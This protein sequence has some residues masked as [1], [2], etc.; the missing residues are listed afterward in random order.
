MAPDPVPPPDTRA[1]LQDAQRL[2]LDDRLGEAEILYRRLL[3]QQPGHAQGLGMLAMLLADQPGRE[4]EAETALH[5]HLAL[6]PADGA[7]LHRLGRLKAGQGDDAAA[8]ALFRRAAVQ[9]PKLAPVFNDLG[10]SLN[11][12][13]ERQ[14]ALAALDHA[15]ALDPV[16]GMAHVNRG[17]VLSDLKQFDQATRAQL[18]ALLHLP[19]TRPDWSAATLYSLLRVVRKTGDRA[20]AETA[21]GIVLATGPTDGGTIDELA[22]LLEYLGR[23]DE[24]RSLRNDVARRTGIRRKAPPSDAEATVLLLGGVGAGHL[25]TRYLVDAQVFATLSVELLSPDQPDAPLGGVDVDRLKDADVVFNTLGEADRDGGQFDAVAA[26]C[27]RLGRPVL[28]PPDAIRRTGRDQATA[29]FGD[30]PDLVTPA[31][32][33]ATPDQ[34]AVLPID[35]PLLVRPAG[36]HGGENLTLLRDTADRDRYLQ[37]P[38]PAAARL[39]LTRFHDFRSPDGHW[40][41]YRLIFVDRRIHPYHLAIGDDW[42]VHYWRTEMSLAPWKK[43]EEA[44]F[45]ADWRGVF[46]APA[47]RAAEE[48]ARR[49]D[50]DYGGMDC[51]LLDDGRLLLF[52]ANACMRV[53]L[54]EPVEAFPY[55]HRHVPAIRDAFSAMV[56][57]R[58][59]AKADFAQS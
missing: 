8:A 47:T 33:A 46:G 10:V 36:D 22:L 13:G 4:A 51:A 54:D 56:R 29:L 11:R 9:L 19:R 50:L 2:H 34:L 30:I 6:R 18:T 14:E 35:A 26:L 53:H 24:A 58:T 21:C 44:R 39:L 49:L 31:V 40:R 42:L 12:L 28:N 48:V 57:E 41:K 7:S 1:L 23:L 20:A 45:L 32:A 55:K 27:A 3:E 43:A 25:P 59:G 16:Y 15:L 5:H 38:P 17:A 52:E 37:K